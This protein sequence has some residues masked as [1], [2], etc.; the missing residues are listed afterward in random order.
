MDARHA[1]GI[2]RV[3]RGR[4]VSEMTAT[5]TTNQRKEADVNGRGGGTGASM[6][7]VTSTTPS[8]GALAPLRVAGFKVLAGGYSINELGNWLRGLRLSALLWGQHGRAK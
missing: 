4:W 7:P 6:P 2:R 3:P 5:I 1:A 8:T